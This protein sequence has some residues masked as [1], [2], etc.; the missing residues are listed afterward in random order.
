MSMALSDYLEAALLNHVFRGNVGGTAMTQPE[1]V[2]MALYTSDPGEDN[3]GAEV[4]TSG[5][6]YI[7]MA[8]T[9]GSP[10]TP[11][12][13]IQNDAAIYFPEAVVDWGLITHFAILDAESSGNLLVY[14]ALVTP[15]QV[16]AGDSVRAS[17]NA[18]G[19]TLD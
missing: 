10:Q 14:G 15:R 17:V 6:G 13:V 5:T 19:I 11:G 16:Y 8:A 4:P 7:R 1:A 12:G 9:F 3:S 18:I 2:F